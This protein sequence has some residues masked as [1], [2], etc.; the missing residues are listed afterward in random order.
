MR[1]KLKLKQKKS[2]A[3]KLSFHLL[4]KLSSFLLQIEHEYG[5]GLSIRSRTTNNVLSFQPQLFAWS[6]T[7]KYKTKARLTS[8]THSPSN[9]LLF[10]PSICFHYATI[11]SSNH[12]QSH[13]QLF[14]DVNDEN[15]LISRRLE[16]SENEKIIR[17]WLD[18][19]YFVLIT[20]SCE[21]M[22]ED[23]LVIITLYLQPGS[24]SSR[25]DS[26]ATQVVS[27]L[28]AITDLHRWRIILHDFHIA[29]SPMRVYYLN[30]RL[31]FMKLSLTN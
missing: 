11:S 3:R 2:T 29:S 14:L 23:I 8:L 26:A 16:K 27:E 31:P 4:F 28:A 17:S 5:A 30:W 9:K 13:G 19:D 10:P 18:F 6:S 7:R 21:L 15:R 24:A 25:S 20:H 22:R 1:N 12:R